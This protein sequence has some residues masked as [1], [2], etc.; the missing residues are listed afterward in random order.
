MKSPQTFDGYDLPVL[1]R[2][3]RLSNWIASRNI[4]PRPVPQFHLRTTVRAGIGLSVKAAIKRVVVLGLAARAH[5]E[6]RHRCARAVVG[7]AAHNSEA[8]SAIC[9]IDEW[10]AIAA[11]RRIKQLAQAIGANRDVRRDQRTSLP[12]LALDNAKCSLILCRDFRFVNAGNSRQRRSLQRKTDRE[13][14]YLLR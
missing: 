2:L 7:D 11:I 3:N 14:V 1:K 12:G 8:R 9:A 4:E 6:H 13:L 5:R 10:V